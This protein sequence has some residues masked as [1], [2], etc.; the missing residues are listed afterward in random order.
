MKKNLGLVLFIFFISL[1]EST[2]FNHLMFFRTKPDLLLGLVVIM[3]LTLKPNQ[4]LVLS[5]VCGICKDIFG[6]GAF[7]AYTLLFPLWCFLI[8]KLSREISLE[9][10]VVCIILVFIVNIAQN[11]IYRLILLFSG[12]YVAWYI[13]LRIIF[14]EA[15]YT[16]AVFPL[17]LKSYRFLKPRNKR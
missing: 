13:F 1:I 16:A 3:A 5:L 12:V 2:V 6:S 4:F 9:N 11:I 7:G 15:I 17:I 10:D 8:N 14:L